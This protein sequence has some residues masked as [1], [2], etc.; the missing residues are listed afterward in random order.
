MWR[1]QV[2]CSWFGGLLL[3]HKLR[4]LH[5][6]VGFHLNSF[7]DNPQICVLVIWWKR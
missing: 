3:Q 7:G 2:L 5:S 1:P 4:I 6:P